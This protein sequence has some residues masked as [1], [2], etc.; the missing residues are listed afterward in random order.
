MKILLLSHNSNSTFHFLFSYSFCHSLI[1]AILLQMKYC[2]EDRRGACL[3]GKST[4]TY[5]I[6]KKPD[7]RFSVFFHS[8][9]G[10]FCKRASLSSPLFPKLILYSLILHKWFPFCNIVIYN[11]KYVFGLGPSLWHKTPKAFGIS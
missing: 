4:V 11:N 6:Y 7:P 8:F 10:V 5:T 1:H 2:L 3:L 9:L